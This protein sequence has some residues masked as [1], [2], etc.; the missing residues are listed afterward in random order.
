MRR[1][2]FITLIGGVASAWSLYARAQQPYRWDRPRIQLVAEDGPE[3]LSDV[4]ASAQ[5]GLRPSLW[6]SGPHL[7]SKL[8]RSKT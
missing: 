2:E 5:G 4:V 3:E 8:D 7:R 1:R 6:R